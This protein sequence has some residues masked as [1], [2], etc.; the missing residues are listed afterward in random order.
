MAIKTIKTS[1]F[2]WHNLTDFSA[3]ELG[4]LKKNFKFHWV[5]SKN[6]SDC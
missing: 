3:E 5:I 4:F 1:D 2:S 6:F